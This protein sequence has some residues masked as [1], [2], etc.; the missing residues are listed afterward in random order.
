MYDFSL[1]FYLFLCPV[2]KKKEDTQG[3]MPN[4][5][6]ARIWQTFNTIKSG[7]KI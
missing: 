7:K 3:E 6:L 5:P 1:S 2:A 4:K